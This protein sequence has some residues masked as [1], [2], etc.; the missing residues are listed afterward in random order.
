MNQS[1]Q[2]KETPHLSLDAV[3]E[4]VWGERESIRGESAYDSEAQGVLQ[5]AL[6]LAANR[7]MTTVKVAYL[8]VPGEDAI[9]LVPA[10][11][12]QVSGGVAYSTFAAA[13]AGLDEARD[14]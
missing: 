5:Q 6:R 2:Q 1:T 4:D 8:I 14:A 13:I 3:I 9:Y 11:E 7:G 10:W 12:A